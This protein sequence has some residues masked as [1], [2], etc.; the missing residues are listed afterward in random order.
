VSQ[1]APDRVVFFGGRRMPNF[2]YHT[3]GAYTPNVKNMIEVK[4]GQDIT[5]MANTF[6]NTYV[7]ADQ[8]GIPI[9]LR[10]TTEGGQVPWATVQRINISDNI[11]HHQGGAVLLGDRDVNQTGPATNNITL[12]N[13][14]FDDLRT[15][16]SFDYERL[17][18]AFGISSLRI[19]HNT[20]LSNAEYFHQ[21]G[22]TPVSNFVYTD[23]IA[24]YGGGFSSDC[25]YNVS[26]YACSF[27]GYSL[28]KNIFIGGN[29]NAFPSLTVA[30][31]YFPS[32]VNA[33]GFVDANNLGADYHNYALA[34]NSPYKRKGLHSGDIGFMPSLYD[35]AR[36]AF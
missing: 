14:L 21:S 17:F 23:N 4:F 18:N 28:N 22:G 5:I 36:S 26:A 13:N 12:Y 31:Q 2:V 15:D 25:G 27:N 19:D 11:F 3:L 32:T 10:P 6:T 24:V 35:Y 29:P 1:T 9:V 7:Q 33:V 20:F 8:F 34:P 16:Y 30:N